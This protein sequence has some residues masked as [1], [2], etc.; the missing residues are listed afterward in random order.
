M[1]KEQLGAT[2]KVVKHILWLTLLSFLVFLQSFPAHANLPNA[3]NGRALPS[4]ADMLERATPAVVNISTQAKRPAREPLLEQFFGRA[5]AQRATG[6]GSGVIFDARNGY[7]VTNNH[8][9]ADANRVM[10]TLND[11]RQFVANIVGRDP[12]ADIAVIQIKAD[13]L[14]QLTFGNSDQLRVGDFVVAIGNP[15]GLGQSVTSGIIS[16]LG[17]S[18]LGIED[19]EDFIQTDAS[20]NPGNSGGALVNLNGQLIGINT[21]ILGG[22]NGGNVGI[23][24]AIP[25]SMTRNIVNQLIKHG[26]VERGQLGV[27]VHDIDSRKAQELGMP[28][29]RGA[30]VAEVINGSPADLSGLKTGD[31]IIRVNGR[32]VRSA[33]DV[34]NKIGGLRLGTRVNVR[35]IRN[36]QHRHYTTVVG[37][38]DPR[39]NNQMPTQTPQILPD[40]PIWEDAQ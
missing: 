1:T 40:V 6:S 18:N 16:A 27:K 34:R 4:L 39:T 5:P 11:G 37:K 33:T 9:V 2:M 20:I 23:G 24:F 26:K 15:Y 30:M 14:A 8:V 36:G 19:Y 31:V 13:K 17:R 29:P 21:A 22:G 7:I 10:V 38:I 25:A 12:R 3:I 32:N 35:V 28:F